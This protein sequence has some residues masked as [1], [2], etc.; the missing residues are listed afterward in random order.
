MQNRNVTSDKRERESKTDVSY[1][2]MLNKAKRWEALG[3]L[4]EAAKNGLLRH[5]LVREFSEV[6]RTE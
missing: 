6:F 2:S 4:R 1:N 5:D 3:Q